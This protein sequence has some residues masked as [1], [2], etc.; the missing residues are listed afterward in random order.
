MS[1]IQ[2]TAL[3][4]AMGAAGDTAA[5]AGILHAE[6]MQQH[7]MSQAGHAARMRMH[8]EMMREHGARMREHGARMREHGAR[9]REHGEIMTR[10]DMVQ[11]A[12]VQD[13]PFQAAA[14]EQRRKRTRKVSLRPLGLCLASSLI[15]AKHR[16]RKAAKKARQTE[17]MDEKTQATRPTALN[18]VVK[19]EEGQEEVKI[20]AEPGSTPSP[21]RPDRE[22]KVKQERSLSP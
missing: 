3:F 13:Q 1:S 8:G 10:H 11:N 22:V 12:S 14:Q 9:M 17:E 16:A 2:H 18:S 6:R 4:H 5:M 21:E 20:K 19:Q 7:M 15:D